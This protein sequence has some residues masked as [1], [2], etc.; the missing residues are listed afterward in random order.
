MNVPKD[1]HQGKPYDP[2]K[3]NT[4]LPFISFLRYYIF[5]VA[6]TSIVL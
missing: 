1:K 4:H 3:L 5:I 2:N 6:Y